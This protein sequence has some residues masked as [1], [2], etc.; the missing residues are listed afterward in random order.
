MNDLLAATNV[1]HTVTA[2]ANNKRGHPSWMPL[3]GAGGELPG[4]R[5]PGNRTL[6]K[7][8][9]TCANAADERR[10]HRARES[11]L[12]IRN[13]AVANSNLVG[14]LRYLDA[15]VRLAASA[16]PPHVD[17]GMCLGHPVLLLSSRSNVAARAP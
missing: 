14:A 8:E 7:V 1:P 10:P 12:G 15:V 6:L 16:L 9:L 17:D 3:R 5:D 2:A 4:R 13:R 11:Q